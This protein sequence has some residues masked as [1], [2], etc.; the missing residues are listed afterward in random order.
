[1]FGVN[2]PTAITE[3]YIYFISYQEY[4]VLRHTRE[5]IIKLTQEFM[6]NK[7]Q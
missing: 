1:M 2:P 6:I 7:L 3:Q 5:N 4:D